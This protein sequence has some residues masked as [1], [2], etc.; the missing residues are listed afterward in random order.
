LARAA[1]LP[2]LTAL[3]VPDVLASIAS[4]LV[5]TIPYELVKLGSKRREQRQAA[6]DRMME[7]LLQ[8]QQRRKRVSYAK[9]KKEASDAPTGLDPLKNP[10][11]SLTSLMSLRTLSS[12]FRVRCLKTDFAGKLF[13]LQMAQP[14]L[15]EL[16]VQCLGS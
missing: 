13:G 1:V 14:F 4:V 9:S 11:I 5:A 3:G 10:K 12:G 6:E 2:L 15:Q 16:K 7:K 8:D